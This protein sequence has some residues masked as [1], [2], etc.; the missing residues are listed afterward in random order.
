MM[1]IKQNKKA[2]IPAPTGTRTFHLAMISW[3]ICRLAPLSGLFRRASVWRRCWHLSL[4]LHHV[5]SAAL[6][7][8]QMV[9]SRPSWPNNQ[10]ELKWDRFL[11]ER[12]FV[13]LSFAADGIWY[14]SHM[15]R[16]GKIHYVQETLAKHYNCCCG[17]QQTNARGSLES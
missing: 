7:F 4:S 16:G 1:I 5:P 9:M 8:G 6:C 17:G 12:Y 14:P 15:Q 2:F 3:L 10:H 11:S 13:L